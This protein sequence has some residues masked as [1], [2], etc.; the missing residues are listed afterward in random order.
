MKW[1]VS[2]AG[3]MR[4]A[5]FRASRSRIF[6]LRHAAD[7]SHLGDEWTQTNQILNRDLGNAVHPCILSGYPRKTSMGGSLQQ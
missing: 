4:S 6:S 7:A 3:T 5:A 2:T 1:M